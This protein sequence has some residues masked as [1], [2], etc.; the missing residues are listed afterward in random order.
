MPALANGAGVA[1]LALFRFAVAHHSPV[2]HRFRT[3]ESPG[4]ISQAGGTRLNGF[5][6]NP[7]D[8]VAQMI[9]CAQRPPLQPMARR[10]GHLSERFDVAVR[11]EHVLRIPSCLDLGE[12][13]ESRAER[14]L[15]ALGAFVLG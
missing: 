7:G 13:L 2:H 8:K 9:G 3:A 15:D 12:P 11:A 14:R 10:I 4:D 5:R 1:F 6:S